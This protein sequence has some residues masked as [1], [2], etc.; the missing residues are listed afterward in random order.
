MSLPSDSVG[1][2]RPNG[3]VQVRYFRHD[4]RNRNPRGNPLRDSRTNQGRRNSFGGQG[5]TDDSTDPQLNASA[6]DFVLFGTLRRNDSQLLNMTHD[7]GRFGALN[8]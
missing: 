2:G 6:Q 4:N 8:T 1:N 5:R 3:S 7:G